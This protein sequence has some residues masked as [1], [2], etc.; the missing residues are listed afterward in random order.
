[1]Q[2]F[3]AQVLIP[4]GNK[5]FLSVQNPVAVLPLACNRADIRKIGPCLRFGQ[6]HGGKVAARC[7]LWQPGMALCIRAKFGNQSGRTRHKSGDHLKGMAGPCQYLA[8][9][10]TDGGGG[11]LTIKFLGQ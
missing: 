8:D 5:D 11:T 6:A 4:A 10:A 2:D 9:R 1:M 7:Q 3:I